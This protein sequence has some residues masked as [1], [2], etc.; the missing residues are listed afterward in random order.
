MF[1]GCLYNYSMSFIKRLWAGPQFKKHADTFAVTRQV[2]R[3]RVGQWVK[4]CIERKQHVLLLAHFKSTFVENV[5]SLESS[6]LDF[7]IL[8]QPL[9]ADQL[10]TRFDKSPPTAWLTMPDMLLES[11]APNQLSAD[12]F[13]AAMIV[14]ERHPLIEADKKLERFAR[15]LGGQ[16]ELGYLLS[17]EDPVIQHA[18][19]QRTIELLKQLGLGRNDLISSH[20]LSRV[21]SK[22]LGRIEGQVVAETEAESPQEWLANNLARNE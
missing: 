19:D 3:K 8:S 6:G 20:M 7:E 16:V 13:S 21:L 1:N 5:E 2:V 14:T 12:R 4:L 11:G 18:I 15:S 9:L 22:M 10:Q 17:L